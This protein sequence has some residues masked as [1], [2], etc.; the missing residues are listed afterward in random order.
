LFSFSSWVENITQMAE[1]KAT[2]LTLTQRKKETNKQTNRKMIW[3]NNI[4][5]NCENCYPCNSNNLVGM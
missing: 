5:I 4:V 1:L 2:K 3:N